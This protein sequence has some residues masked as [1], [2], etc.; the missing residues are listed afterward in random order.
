MFICFF[1]GFTLSR[2]FGDSF[3]DVTVPL[4]I[5]I[6]QN[7][8]TD[9]AMANGNGELYKYLLSLVV[10]DDDKWNLLIE[11]DPR[12]SHIFPWHNLLTANRFV[13]V[14]IDIEDKHFAV[15]SNGSQYRRRIWCPFDV[16]N[17]RT[18]IE[19]KKWF[20]EKRKNNFGFPLSK[21]VECELN[22][23]FSYPPRF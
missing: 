22:F 13:F 3:N 6:L 4:Q 7:Q 23:T 9:S 15:G 10:A 2:R 19:Y 5:Y 16:T 17:T 21:C 18:Q 14:D 12:E 1:G 11:C 20:T 8:S